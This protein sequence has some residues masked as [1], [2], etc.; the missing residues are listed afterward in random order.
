VAI[1]EM[2]RVGELKYRENSTGYDQKAK[3]PKALVPM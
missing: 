2:G 3:Y 1:E